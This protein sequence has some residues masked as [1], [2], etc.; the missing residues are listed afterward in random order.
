MRVI[1]ER[2]RREEEGEFLEKRRDDSRREIEKISVGK[3]VIVLLLITLIV[4]LSF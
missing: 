4:S 3:I 2:K 1:F